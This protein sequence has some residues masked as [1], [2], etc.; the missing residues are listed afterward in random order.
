M[1]EISYTL[2]QRLIFLNPVRVMPL[3]ER[4]IELIEV[5]VGETFEIEVLAGLILH[6]ACILE[7]STQPRGMLVIETVRTQIE[8]LFAREL[9]IC[10]LTFHILTAQISRPISDE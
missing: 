8:Q 5:E 4:M 9:S 3:I 10:H 2:S 1:R 7:R 6:L